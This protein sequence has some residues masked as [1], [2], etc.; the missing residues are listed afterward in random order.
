[1]SAKMMTQQELCDAVYQAVFTADSPLT[2]LMI[3][4]RIG[5]Q[6]S[7]HIVAMIE[8][9]C[10]MGYFERKMF[11]DNWKRETF[12]YTLVRNDSPDCS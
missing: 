4:E 10:E 6:K 12:V 3:C 5:K 9:L 1:M 8:R 11:V 7:P 2:R